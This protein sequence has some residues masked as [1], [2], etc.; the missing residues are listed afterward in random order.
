MSA[1][2][3]EIEVKNVD[4][5]ICDYF[6]KFKVSESMN[7][8]MNLCYRFPPKSCDKWILLTQ[9]KA[10]SKYEIKRKPEMEKEPSFWKS[11]I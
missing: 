5:F 2:H 6:F 8:L 3:L 10:E 9:F 1:K 11:R 7:C 4:L